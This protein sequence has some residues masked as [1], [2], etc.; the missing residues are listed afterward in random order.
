LRSSS[1]RMPR[2]RAGKALNSRWEL[3]RAS[4]MPPSATYAGVPVPIRPER[5]GVVIGKD[6]K[7]LQ[8][9]EKAFNVRIQ[10]DSQTATAF[11]APAEGATPYEVMRAKQAVE[12]ISLGFSLEDA[13]SL[14]SEE[15]CFEVIDLSEAARNPEDL[16]RIKARVIGEEGRARRNIE[17]MAGVKIVVGD[18]VVGIL[19]EC[20][21]VSVARKA[22]MML[23]EGRT[24]ATVYG[25]L[26]SAARELKRRRLQ[27]WEERR[28][29]E[30]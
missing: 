26:R 3:L 27:L 18:K 25:F 15:Y 23:V 24:H 13:L 2:P 1:A 6:G 21:N 30:V 20:E 9:L 5:L 12:A 11:I 10:V 22:L 16:K 17:Q 7:N 14:S 29:S 4:A 28:P 8:T 19:G